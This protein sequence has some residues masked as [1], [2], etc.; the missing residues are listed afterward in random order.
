[1]VTEQVIFRILSVLGM[2]YDEI[3]QCCDPQL[4]GVTHSALLNLAVPES[5][6]AKKIRAPQVLGRISVLV[7]RRSSVIYTLFL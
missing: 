6:H 3:Q 2:L 1:M 5:G 7:V 4:A